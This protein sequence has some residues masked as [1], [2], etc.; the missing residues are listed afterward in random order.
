MV[1]GLWQYP[2]EQKLI[3]A[4]P[5]I[6]AGI[7]HGSGGRKMC[8]FHTKAALYLKF[9]DDLK[10]VIVQSEKI[11]Y[12]DS[13]DTIPCYTSE[14]EKKTLAEMQMRKVIEEEWRKR[15]SLRRI[16][17]LVSHCPASCPCA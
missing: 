16:C 17:A 9:G 10:N 7:I 8:E 12:R 4:A 3:K 11:E 15:T 2:M 14:A 1:R 5:N 13:S 6:S